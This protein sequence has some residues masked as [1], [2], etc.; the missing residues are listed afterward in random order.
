[1]AA[2]PESG[3]GV[4]NAG[5][6]VELPGVLELLW[7]RRERGRRGPRSG[8]SIEQIVSAAIG[9]ADAEGLDA[10]SMARVASELGF[11][12]MALYRY[13]QSKDE[14]LQLMWNA[15][16]ADAPTVQGDDWRSAL[17]SWGLQQWRMLQ[18][19]HWVL[20]M[21]MAS[22]PAGPSSLSWVEQAMAALE[23]T[24]LNEAEKLG[25]VGLLSAYALGEARLDHQMQLAVQGGEPPVD[26][27]AVLRAVT[28][29]HTHP[30]LHRAAWS[31]EL[32]EPP[33]R[34]LAADAE[35]GY[36]FGMELIL[37]G[38]QALIDSRRRQTGDSAAD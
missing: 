23:G 5:G 30:A 29:E 18:R 2:H 6:D 21:P 14:L 3:E 26:Y 19:R 35:A 11:T 13:V 16:A 33:D 24:G 36:V 9:V 32:D 27:A 25:V 15:A 7:G 12:P 10:V 1:M 34:D 38:V 31:G 20:D 8:L 4:P 37:N 22:P 17:S 28:D